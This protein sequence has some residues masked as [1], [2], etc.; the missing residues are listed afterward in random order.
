MD[1]RS[2]SEYQFKAAKHVDEDYFCQSRGDGTKKCALP[3]FGTCFLTHIS[4][5]GEC[6]VKMNN[7]KDTFLMVKNGSCKARC[8][9]VN[10]WSGMWVNE[11]QPVSSMKVIFGDF[12]TS[13][14]EEKF[15]TDEFIKASWTKHGRVYS[16]YECLS[17]KG[18]PG[19]KCMLPSG[20]SCFLTYLAPV[21]RNCDI[22][23]NGG[24]NVYV[25]AKDG[26][27]GVRCFMMEYIYESGVG[28]RLLA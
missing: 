24:M 9:M 11:I 19:K 22:V 10:T 26:N 20:A 27:C 23:D 3:S 4:G 21:S 6:A 8:Y 16:E 14:R 25:D 1:L 15:A 18:Y 17:A 28:R 2:K 5:N 12:D 13:R 7:S